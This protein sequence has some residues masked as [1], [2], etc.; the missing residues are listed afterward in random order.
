MI[1]L[2]HVE[3]DADIREIA[4]MALDLTGEFEVVQ[5]SSGMEALATITSYTP[6]VVL[7]DMMMPGMTGRQTL[8]KMRETP[9]LANVPAVF[10]T[11]RAQHAEIDELLQIGAAEVIS[12][13]FDPM[14]LPDQIKRAMKKVR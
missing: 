11:A 3:D 1:R 8:E 5:C 12:K 10:M 13:P 2:L 4:L 14:A 6:D 7:L 9:A